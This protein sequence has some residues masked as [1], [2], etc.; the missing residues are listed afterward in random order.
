MRIHLHFDSR[1]K[2]PNYMILQRV[3]ESSEIKRNISTLTSGSD[4]TMTSSMDAKVLRKK[5]SG[6]ESKSELYIRVR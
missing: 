1:E 3:D 6:F 5:T 2:A 4:E